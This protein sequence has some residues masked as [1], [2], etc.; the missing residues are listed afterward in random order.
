MN[1]ATKAPRFAQG[2]I[3]ALQRNNATKASRFAQGYIVA[4]QKNRN[5]PA[6]ACGFWSAVIKA[7]QKIRKNRRDIYCDCCLATEKMSGI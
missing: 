6:N 1:N 5:E 3:V 4:L 7:R 2:Y